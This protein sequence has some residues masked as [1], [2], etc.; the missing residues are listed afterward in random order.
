MNYSMGS[1]II[2][3]IRASKTFSKFRALR[4]SVRFEVP[5]ASK[6]RVLRSSVRFEVPCASKFRAHRSS[7]WEPLKTRISDERDINTFVDLSNT[8]VDRAATDRLAGLLK[9]IRALQPL[10]YDVTDKGD[11]TEF[12]KAYK[13]MDAVLQDTTNIIRILVSKLE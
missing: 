8:L 10:L 4:S 13:K 6:F 11:F 12:Q 2:R 5:C 7:V 1:G 3:Y 9:L